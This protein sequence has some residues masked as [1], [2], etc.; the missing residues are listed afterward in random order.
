MLFH[1][2][3]QAAL[4]S[5]VAVQDASAR[6]L[7]GK[8]QHFIQPYKRGEP[9]QDIVTWDEHSLLIRGKRVMLYSGEFHPVSATVYDKAR[10]EILTNRPTSSA[11]QSP[12]S[13]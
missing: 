9:L 10:I 2:L 3:L 12:L 6:A 7:A 13:G 4:L 11:S 5:C 1:K 8:P